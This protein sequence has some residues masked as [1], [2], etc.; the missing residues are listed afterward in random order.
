MAGAGAG[1]V[2]KWHI[3][4][5]YQ[6]KTQHKLL[7][8]RK[9]VTLNYDYRW[10][11]LLWWRQ[12][13]KYRGRKKRLYTQTKH[14]LPPKKLMIVAAGFMAQSLLCKKKNNPLKKT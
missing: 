12:T 4:E 14:F 10:F 3:E 13:K 2:S 1:G 5:K 8:I 9:F 11:Q 6:K 7:G